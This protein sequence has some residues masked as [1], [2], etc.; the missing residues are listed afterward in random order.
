MT[1]SSPPLSTE[2]LR[3]HVGRLPRFPLAHLPTPLEEVP[4][5]SRE[6]GGPR[7]HIK[8][9]DCTGLAFGGN[10]ARHNEFVLGDALSKQADMFVWGAGVQSNNCRQTAASCAKAGLDCHLVLGRGGPPRGE[11]RVGGNLLLDHLLG[12]SYEIVDEGIGDALDRRIHEVAERFRAAGR[13]V[14]SWD[15]DVVKPL[16]AVSYILC[17]IEILE[18]SRAEGWKPSAVYVCSAGSTGSGVAIAGAALGVDFPIKSIC[19]IQWEWDTQE[20]MAQIGNR[21]AELLGLETRLSRADLDISFDFIGP[22]YG[23]FSEGGTEAIRL[24]ARNEGILL[25]P[26]YSGKAMAGLMADVRAGQYSADEHVV[27]IHTG[28]TPALFACEEELTRQIPR[29]TITP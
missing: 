9:D 29:R 16:A 18:Q 25:D 8:R 2:Q 14:Y 4:R 19:P 7:I 5:F 26:S 27:M 23:K 17:L 22:G 3:E 10:K 20:D 24:L 28:G 11:D 15:R 21:T 13:R 6:L 1:T 12:A